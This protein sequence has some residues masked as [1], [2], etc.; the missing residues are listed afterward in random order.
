MRRG[1]K[2]GDE[3][4]MGGRG[5]EFKASWQLSWRGGVNAGI[6]ERDQVCIRPSSP[7]AW[8]LELMDGRKG[9]GNLNGWVIGLIEVRG[10]GGGGKI[11]RG[12]GRLVDEM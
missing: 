2:T 9:V 7:A 10:G 11:W 1:E 8:D 4:G 12:R 6:Q 5:S 3:D